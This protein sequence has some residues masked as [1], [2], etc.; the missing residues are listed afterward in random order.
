MVRQT[1]ALEAAIRCKYVD[2]AEVYSGNREE[3]ANGNCTRAK[4]NTYYN[5]SNGGSMHEAQNAGEAFR[6]AIPLL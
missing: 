3:Q 2:L 6:D 5:I 4:Y 1:N